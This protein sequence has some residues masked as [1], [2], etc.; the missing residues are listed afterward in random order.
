MS[1]KSNLAIIFGGRSSE[2]DVS[3]ISVRT[4]IKAVDKAR[5]DLYIVGITKEGHWL[6]VDDATSIEDGSWRQSKKRAIIT[7]I[8]RG[9]LLSRTKER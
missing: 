2:H 4:I 9:C 1:D 3:C 8:R 7:P 6:L 5:Y